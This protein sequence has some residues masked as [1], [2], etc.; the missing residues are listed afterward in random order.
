MTKQVQKPKGQF[1]H[2]VKWSIGE[3]YTFFAETRVDAESYVKKV[4]G[5]LD[6][7]LI[8]I[9]ELPSGKAV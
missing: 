7:L 1:D 5:N 8:H 3:D 4:G 6:N 2:Y 9:P